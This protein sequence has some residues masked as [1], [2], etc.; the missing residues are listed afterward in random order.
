MWKRDIKR[1][2]REKEKLVFVER[3]KSDANI[4][5][6]FHQHSTGSFYANSILEILLAHS[7]KQGSQAR[8][9]QAACAPPDAFVRPAEHFF[10]GMWPS[11]QFEFETP[12]LKSKSWA[13][14]L[15]IC[16][17][18]VRHIFVGETEQHLLV[19][20]NDYRRICALRHR[21]GE[22]DSWFLHF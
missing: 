3:W 8:G 16:T 10:F 22:I 11:D 2:K 20:K 14:F 13:Y 4:Q 7:L 9:P 19:P 5:T 15:A 21:V 6:Q 18:K 17:S 1:K 12:D